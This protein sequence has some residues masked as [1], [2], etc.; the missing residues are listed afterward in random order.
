MVAFSVDILS[1]G[2][3]SF[4][5]TAM[6]ASSV[7]MVKG[8]SPSV[9][10]IGTWEGKKRALS[11]WL[12]PKT[13]NLKNRW[14]L[15]NKYFNWHRHPDY[16]NCILIKSFNNIKTLIPLLN[17]QVSVNRPWAGWGKA[18]RCCPSAQGGTVSWNIQDKKQMLLLGAHHHTESSPEAWSY[19]PPQPSAHFRMLNLQ[20]KSK[21]R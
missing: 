15:K 6:S 18:S 1:A 10:G 11:D 12:N 19:W 21:Y 7:S 5:Q 9:T 4:C 8:S 2:S 16:P 20:P 3:P 14:N 13:L 17:K